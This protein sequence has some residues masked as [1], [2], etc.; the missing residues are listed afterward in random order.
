MLL[1]GREL[2]AI[3]EHF[4]P[5]DADGNLLPADRRVTL[6]ASNANIPLDIQAR[7]FAMAAAAGRQSPM[8]VQVSYNSAETIGND[9]ARI[10]VPEGVTRQDTE[11]AVVIG[12]RKLAETLYYHAASYGARYLALALDHFQVPPYDEK[13]LSQVPK[14]RKNLARHLAEAR[15]LHAAE[16]MYPVF[17]A[18]AK[19]TDKLMDLYVNYLVSPAYATFRRNFLATVWAARPAWGM[20]DTE[21]LPPILDFVV[22]REIVDSVRTL[23]GEKEMMIEAEFG[24]TGQ[25]GQAV[26][27]QRL[28]GDQLQQFARQVASFVMYTGADGIAYP[29]GME[30]AAKKDEKHEPDEERLKVVQRELFLAVGKY[31]PFAQHGGTGAA[32]IAKGLVGKNN[33]NT[34][35]LVAGA[36]ALADWVEKNVEGIRQGDK[37]CAGTGLFMPMIQAVVDA[38]LGKLQ[39]AG[40]RDTGDQVQAVLA[41]LPQVKQTEERFREVDH[42]AE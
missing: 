36:N 27:Y 3:F 41:R 1:S 16:Y 20:I 21:K 42:H 32:S 22:T 12:A 24:A 4:C 8:M 14:A 39:E 26:E 23:L 6:L 40:S 15:V 28:T 29:I 18:E 31:V 30:H 11:A 13:V 38:T 19:L 5:F 17:G 10:P 2:R 37:K 7:A 25:S 33:I 35:Y 34:H 9:T